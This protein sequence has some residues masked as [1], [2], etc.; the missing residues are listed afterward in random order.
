MDIT[1]GS[2]RKLFIFIFSGSHLWKNYF[3]HSS[4]IHFLN[5]LRKSY[6]MSHKKTLR[7][8]FAKGKKK[9]MKK[10]LKILFAKA[11]KKMRIFISTLIRRI[12]D[13]TDKTN[14]TDTRI[15]LSS[16][17]VQQSHPGDE[18]IKDITNITVIT[19]IVL[20][21]WTSWTLWNSSSRDAEIE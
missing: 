20:Y 11:F 12:A 6:K 2:E 9:L 5:I 3:W 10:P 21:S 1:F 14:F 18:V 7:T 13:T 19:D 16:N 15:P 4:R 17:R 8:F